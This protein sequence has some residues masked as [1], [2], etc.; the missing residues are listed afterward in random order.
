[1]EP[2]LGEDTAT[3]IALIGNRDTKWWQKGGGWEKR[4]KKRVVKGLSVPLVRTPLLTPMF[5]TMKLLFHYTPSVFIRLKVLRS[6]HT[7]SEQIK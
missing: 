2:R 7:S 1:M 6:A 5:A 3:V 4:K